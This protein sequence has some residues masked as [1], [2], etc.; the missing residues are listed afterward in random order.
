MPTKWD[1]FVGQWSDALPR[2][3][4]I[5]VWNWQLTCMCRS[6]DGVRSQR[7]LVEIRVGLIT[8]PA[9]L[10]SITARA[11]GD[12]PASRVATGSLPTAWYH[13]MCPRVTS[14][15]SATCDWLNFYLFFLRSA[16]FCSDAERP[17][18]SPFREHFTVT[19]TSTAHFLNTNSRRKWL[20]TQNC[21]SKSEGFE[22]MLRRFAPNRFIPERGEY[23]ILSI[24]CIRYFFYSEQ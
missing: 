19:D 3:R 2:R 22:P 21:N 12:W 13:V 4:H 20:Q 10:Q 17:L 18:H 8:T 24:T 15:I 9:G 6:P 16:P 11:W 14:M 23:C 1:L 5:D 7:R